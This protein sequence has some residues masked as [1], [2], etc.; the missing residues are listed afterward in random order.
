MDKKLAAVWEQDD[1]QAMTW[2]WNS[3]GPEVFNNV[4][5]EETSKEIWEAL[6]EICS[7]DQD[8]SHTYQL[9]QDFFLAQ[10]NRSVDNITQN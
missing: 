2:L 8:I 5:V 7:S 3:L 6:R 9:Y 4:S 1:A 10:E